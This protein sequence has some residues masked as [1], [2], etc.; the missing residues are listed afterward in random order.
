M[1]NITTLK[2]QRNFYA[3]HSQT[4]AFIV[5]TGKSLIDIHAHKLIEAP[6]ETWLALHNDPQRLLD[7]EQTTAVLKKLRDYLT[8]I[9][10]EDCFDFYVAVKLNKII[11]QLPKSTA[12]NK[13]FYRLL[14][15]YLSTVNDKIMQRKQRNQ[16]K[17]FTKHKLIDAQRQIKILNSNIK[18]LPEINF[19]EVFSSAVQKL[20]GSHTKRAIEWKLSFQE[21]LLNTLIDPRILALPQEEYDTY[22]QYS[23]NALQAAEDTFFGQT[24]LLHNNIAD[25]FSQNG[26][27]IKL[28]AKH[29]NPKVDYQDNIDTLRNI[30]TLMDHLDHYYPF[31]NSAFKNTK[32]LTTAI[33]TQ[34]KIRKQKTHLSRVIFNHS[35][36]ASSESRDSPTPSGSSNHTSSSDLEAEHTT[37]PNSAENDSIS[38]LSSGSTSTATT[39][40]SQ[41]RLAEQFATLQD[42]SPANASHRTTRYYGLFQTVEAAEDASTMAYLW[43]QAPQESTFSLFSP[44][45]APSYQP[46]CVKKLW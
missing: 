20:P 18:A 43:D 10:E 25:W 5:A 4:I 24:K 46:S 44:P 16:A 15:A 31:Y 32:D 26:K 7:T 11:F 14:Q 21:N 38:T 42:T 37:R 17:D 3:I 34:K 45:Q 9:I 13:A 33:Q 27:I 19:H 35:K 22:V 39:P 8:R 29:R 23:A 41:S 40:P 6:K 30:A 1:K 2:K 28:L 36:A 12:P